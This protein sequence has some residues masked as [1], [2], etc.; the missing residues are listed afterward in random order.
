ME[1]KRMMF[2]YSF[3]SLLVTAK[4]VSHYG[5][6][7]FELLL[8]KL[9]VKCSHLHTLEGI[10]RASHMIIFVIIWNE[11]ENP[12]SLTHCWLISGYYFSSLGAKIMELTWR[13]SRLVHC[14]F[15]VWISSAVLSSQLKWGWPFLL[16]AFLLHC[17]HLQLFITRPYWIFS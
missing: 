16:H 3:H 12:C 7:Q 11:I 2:P 9:I 10:Q 15:P 14:R 13:S 8:V 6:T 1:L 4:T 5:L 17:S